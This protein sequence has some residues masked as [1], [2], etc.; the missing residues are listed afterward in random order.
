MARSPK[1]PSPPLDMALADGL[2]PPVAGVDEAGRGPWAGPLV[3]AAVILGSDAPEGLDDSK[4]LSAARRAALEAALQ[5]AA[6]EGRAAIGIG[7]VEAAEIDRIGLGPANDAAMC[8][9]VAALGTAPLGPPAALMLDGRRVPPANNLPARA[10]VGGDGRVS[11]I[12]AA[13]IIAKVTRDRLMDALDTRYPGYGWATNRGYGTA[14]HAAA[15]ADL[16]PTP[17]HR[18]SFRPIAR[19]FE[20]RTVRSE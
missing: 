11:A 16:G 2:P 14:A 6:L 12:A 15:L 10:I 5:M 1:R 18:R 20:Q 8:R 4:R 7:V 9:A 19:L 17:E 13:S 3:A